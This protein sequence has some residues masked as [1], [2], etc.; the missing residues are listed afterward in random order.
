MK[1]PRRQFLH[2]AASAAAL[3]VLSHIARAQAYPS[4]PV[5]TIIPFAPAGPTN[6]FGRG[7]AHYCPR[8]QH[9]RKHARGIR[10]QIAFEIE[11]WAKVIRPVNIK[12][13]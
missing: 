12:A 9:S 3:A 7:G 13:E 1:L 5:R 8:L 10:K 2:L 4:R 11:K 6:V